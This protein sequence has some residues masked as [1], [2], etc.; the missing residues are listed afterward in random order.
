MQILEK[1]SSDSRRFDI[2]CSLL[3]SAGETIS[4]VAA[5]TASPVTIPPLTFG[6]PVVNSAPTTYIDQWGNSRTVISGQAVQ[7]QISGGAIPSIARSQD[8]ILRLILTTNQ[9]P[10]IEA[11]VKLRLIDTPT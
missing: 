7:V 4:G 10:A 6:T 5:P 1:R 2:D 8:Y 3:L 9:N 11:T